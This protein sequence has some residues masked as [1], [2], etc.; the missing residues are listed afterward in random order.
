MSS[1]EGRI[2]RENVR[3]TDTD[4][5]S[6]TATIVADGLARISSVGTH[7]ALR[8]ADHDLL[9]KTAPLSPSVRRTSRPKHAASSSPPNNSTCRR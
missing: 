5:L 6:T 4:P 7:D 8:A 2:V 1:E 3:M 9:G